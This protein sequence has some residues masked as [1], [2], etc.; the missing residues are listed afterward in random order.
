MGDGPDE[1]ILHPLECLAVGDVAGDGRRADHPASHIPD[2][3]YRE[4]HLDAPAF[5]GDIHRLQALG[6][7]LSYDRRGSGYFSPDRFSLLEAVGGYNLLSGMWEG[8]F[9]GGLGAQQIGV[10]GDAQS[11]WHLEARL[12][13]QWGMGNRVEAF[14]LVT[15][16]AVSSTSGG[17]PLSVGRDVDQ[18]GVVTRHGV[19]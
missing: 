2:R 15:N 9:S 12:G 18:A 16:S 17:V 7:T 4:R 14:G 10:Q 1:L 3:R 5:L 11:E 6:R 13:R 19:T 8:R